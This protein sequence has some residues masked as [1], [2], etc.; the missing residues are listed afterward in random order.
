MANAVKDAIKEKIEF[1]E[2]L[3]GVTRHKGFNYWLLIPAV[4]M[5]VCATGGFLWVRRWLNPSEK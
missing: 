5:V 3:D 4:L 1:M 2:E